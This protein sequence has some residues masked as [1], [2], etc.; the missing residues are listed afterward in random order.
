MRKP[1]IPAVLLAEIAH[2]VHRII[3]QTVCVIFKEQTVLERNFIKHRRT[4]AKQIDRAFPIIFFDQALIEIEPEHT[5]FALRG[6]IT[7]SSGAGISDIWVYLF[8][9]DSEDGLLLGSAITDSSGAWNIKGLS[10]M[11]NTCLYYESSDYIFTENGIKVDIQGDVV[12]DPVIASLGTGDDIDMD[13][14]FSMSASEVQTGESVTFVVN[15]PEATHVRLVVDEVGYEYYELSDGKASITRS[16][17]LSG[18]RSIQF[19]PHSLNGDGKISSAQTLT[20]TSSGQLEQASIKAIDTQVTWHGFD[21]EW[22]T[23]ENA[24]NYTVYL[25]HNGVQLWPSWNNATEAR[26]SGLSIPIP[27]DYLFEEGDYYVSVVASGNNF[28]SSTSGVNFTVRRTNQ[29]VEVVEYPETATIGTRVSATVA[30]VEKNMFSQLKVIDPNGAL[31][32]AKMNGCSYSFLADIP[33]TYVLTPYASKNKDFTIESA[34]AIGQTV[35]VEVGKPEVIA[36][37]D[38]WKNNYAVAFTEQTTMVACQINCEGTVKVYVNDSYVGDATRI[39]NEQGVVEYQYDK[40]G[41]LDDGQY[42]VRF[43]AVYNGFESSDTESAHIPFYSITLLSEEGLI[44]YASENT[45]YYLQPNREVKDFLSY[46]QKVSLLGTCLSD[47]AY[48]RYGNT[49]CFV[50]KDKVVE[51]IPADESSVTDVKYSH[52]SVAFVNDTISMVLTVEKEIN[53]ASCSVVYTDPKGTKMVSKRYDG[54]DNGDGTYTISFQA[55]KEGV[56]NI[57]LFVYSIGGKSILVPGFSKRL[58]AVTRLTQTFNVYRNCEDSEIMFSDIVSDVF[59]TVSVDANIPMEVLGFYSSYYYVKYVSVQD[60]REY[61]G[62][63][64]KDDVDEKINE[65]VKRGYIL[66][67][68]EMAK[69]WNSTIPS[70]RVAKNMIDLFHANSIQLHG[71]RLD[72]TTDDGS[73]NV[74]SVLDSI[75]DSGAD[76]NDITYVYWFSHGASNTE[77]RS[78]DNVAVYDIDILQRLQRVPGKIVFIVDSCYSGRFARIAR[79]GSSTITENERTSTFTISL[80]RNEFFII[81][82][83]EDNETSRFNP[84]NLPYFSE[85]LIR[86]CSFPYIADSNP[87]DGRIT[88]GELISACPETYYVFNQTFHTDSFGDDSFVLFSAHE[89]HSF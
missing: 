33:G 79:E 18:N 28:D 88:L 73:S 44:R 19:Q 24:S 87:K 37:Y 12:L 11:N 85:N 25:Y 26:T 68:K 81:T 58:T 15:A 14:S 34:E 29:A 83:S 78:F 53:A 67:S 30:C 40:L 20:V 64:Y 50:N 52:D 1:G 75:A 43:V 46:G 41:N 42:D 66:I 71:I 17:S 56:Y 59:E 84:F 86:V 23:V 5:N 65:T 82:A 45:P 35:S 6:V 72:L 55:D 57:S 80:D 8:S 51:T 36:C 60:N 21:V 9:S 22:N 27:G 89:G 7:S 63:V 70:D 13:V 69:E 39:I 62:F 2:F 31:V 76:W 4:F 16:F 32:D 54:I 74:Y 10:A 47:C 3:F 49:Y 77:A 61:H 48:I 38:R